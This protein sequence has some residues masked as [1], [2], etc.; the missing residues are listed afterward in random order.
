MTHLNTRQKLQC[1]ILKLLGINP[2]GVK[3]AVISFSAADVPMNVVVEYVGQK[4]WHKG[5]DV[6]FAGDALQTKA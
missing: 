3:S 4:D 2:N 1:D 5:Q 6:K